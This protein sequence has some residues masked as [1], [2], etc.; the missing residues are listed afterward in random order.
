MTYSQSE[1]SCQVSFDSIKQF[2]TLSSPN[3]PPLHNS[4]ISNNS[5]PPSIWN[6]ENLHIIMSK[7]KEIETILTNIIIIP[8]ISLEA[9]LML[10]FNFP[11]LLWAVALSSA[12]FSF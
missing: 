11:P 9:Y 8:Q 1:I 7:L 12:I 5:Q 10:N 4:C 3:F 6:I 2:P